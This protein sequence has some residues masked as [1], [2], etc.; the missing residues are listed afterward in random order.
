[1]L[2][3]RKVKVSDELKYSSFVFPQVLLVKSF[4]ELLARG[5]DLVKDR[6]LWVERIFLLKECNAYVLEEHD[7][8]TGVRFVLSG[9]DTHE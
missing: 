7:L 3:I 1:M 5:H 9:K 8:S 4:G 2:G 6:L